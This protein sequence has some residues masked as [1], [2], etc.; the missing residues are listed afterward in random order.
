MKDLKM[1]NKNIIYKSRSKE[2]DMKARLFAATGISCGLL[3]GGYAYATTSPSRYCEMKVFTDRKEFKDW[4]N[5]KYNPMTLSSK[6]GIFNTFRC[7]MAYNLYN[8]VLYRTDFSDNRTASYILIGGV[9]DKNPEFHTFKSMRL[10]LDDKEHTKFFNKDILYI[11]LNDHIQRICLNTNGEIKVVYRKGI[12]SRY[13]I[14]VSLKIQKIIDNMRKSS[15]PPPT[16]GS[17]ILNP[18]LR[19]EQL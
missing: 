16:S 17:L 12:K 3:Y 14:P 2:E 6:S 5:N 11:S 13:I 15:S 10:L 9:T 1:N 7:L 18:K 8:D 4:I 19:H